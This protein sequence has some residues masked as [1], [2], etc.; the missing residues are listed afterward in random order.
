MMTSSEQ[1]LV[2]DAGKVLYTFDKKGR[3]TASKTYQELNVPASVAKMQLVD[4][5]LYLAMSNDGSLYSCDLTN[6]QCGIVPGFSKVARRT[7]GFAVTKKYIYITDTSR[8][9]LKTFDKTGELI[10][11]SRG[12]SVPLCYPNQLSFIDGELYVAD[13]NNHRLAIID[14][15][16]LTALKIDTAIA[17]TGDNNVWD[18][19][20]SARNLPSWCIPIS[21]KILEDKGDAYIERA[22]DFNEKMTPSAPDLARRGRIWPTAFEYNNGDWWILAGNNGFTNGD[23]LIYRDDKAI[24][25][26]NDNI[27]EF[28][29]IDIELFQ[30][31]MLVSDFVSMQILKFSENGNWMGEFGDLTFQQDMRKLKNLKAR[32]KSYISVAQKSIFILVLF[33][34]LIAILDRIY[35]KKS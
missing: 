15:S 9:T 35:K 23:V 30:Q 29:P 22:F 32:Y 34:F 6:W 8:H 25:R 28:D 17:I 2:L 11:N 24:K 14:T 21:D 31:D 26:I 16:D 27:E 3:I 10:A 19:I 13:T 7:F 18:I 1:V 4:N 5:I 20:M 12:T 33:A